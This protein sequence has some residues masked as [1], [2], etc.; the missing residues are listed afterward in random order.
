MHTVLD[1]FNLAIKQTELYSAN[2]T[3]VVELLHDISTREI[4]QVGKF[5]NAMREQHLNK[6]I[7]NS[8]QIYN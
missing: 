1:K 8:K 3:L 5:G 4:V 7:N 2:S 6:S